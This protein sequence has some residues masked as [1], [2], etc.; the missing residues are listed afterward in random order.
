MAAPSRS[1]I[2]IKPA[3]YQLFLDA[4]TNT[5]VHSS[6][7]VMKR[8]FGLIV[9][10]LV[11]GGVTRAV[12]LCARSLCPAQAILCCCCTPLKPALSPKMQAPRHGDDQ[13]GGTPATL[14]STAAACCIVSPALPQQPGHGA[15]SPWGSFAH[16]VNEAPLL[17]RSIEPSEFSA[18]WS[19]LAST[20][21]LY[22]NGRQAYL[23]LTILRI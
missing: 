12:V 14:K 1:A 2:Q 19:M 11:S 9:V 17:M 22:L 20:G 6:C 7:L 23:R 3:F 4:I 21:V 13:P 16:S 15:I 18:S 5:L 10:L 8:I